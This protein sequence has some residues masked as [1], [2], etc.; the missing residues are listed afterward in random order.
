MT[1]ADKIL[2]EQIF[3]NQPLFRNQLDLVTQLLTDENTPYFVDQQ[4]VDQYSKAQTRLKTYIS[5]ILSTSVARSITEDFKKGLN[6]LLSKKL[7]GTGHDS[8]GIVNL[9]IEDLKNKNSKITRAEV[10]TSVTEQFYSDLI[11]ASYIAVITS[12]PL[13]IEM[14]SSPEVFSLRHFLFTD[15]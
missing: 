4:N 3:D 11:A 12:K 2:F 6:A 5:Q 1:S 7:K 14:D 10:K 15:L 13:E 9:I 8:E